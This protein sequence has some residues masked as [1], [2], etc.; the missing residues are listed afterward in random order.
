MN[1]ADKDFRYMA[2][3]DLMTELQKENLSLDPESEEK[4]GFVIPP[5]PCFITLF[6]RVANLILP[7]LQCPRKLIPS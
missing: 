6:N 1:E 4:V 2:L 7:R 5:I 3:T